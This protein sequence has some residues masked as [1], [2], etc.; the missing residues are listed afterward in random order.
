MWYI[1]EDGKTIHTAELHK[2]GIILDTGR[3]IE[4]KNIDWLFAT[5]PHTNPYLRL[6][7]YGVYVY[8]DDIEP[9][10]ASN[11]RTLKREVLK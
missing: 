4:E 2:D 1:T 7:K 11:W 6:D 8:C 5:E 3:V 9:T 10:H